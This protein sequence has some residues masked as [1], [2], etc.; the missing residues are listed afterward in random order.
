M[1]APPTLQPLTLTPCRPR[2]SQN[3]CAVASSAFSV[4]TADSGMTRPPKLWPRSASSRWSMPGLPDPL[5]GRP[6]ARG[7]VA[8]REAAQDSFHRVSSECSAV[9]L[10]VDR[11]LGRPRPAIG[12]RATGT[13]T[14][15]STTRR[16]TPALEHVEQDLRRRPR[17]ASPAPGAGRSRLGPALDVPADQVLE[18]GD[19]ADERGGDLVLGAALRQGGG[20]QARRPSSGPALRRGR[21]AGSGSWSSG[22][23]RACGDHGQDLLAPAAAGAGRLK[24]RRASRSRRLAGWRLAI[25]TSRSSRRTWRS[26]RF[27][28]AG[29]LARHSASRRAISRPRRLSWC[30]PGSRRQRSSSARF[31]IAVDEIARTRP[32]PRRSGPARASRTD[33]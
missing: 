30:R 12:S 2:W 10:T 1:S 22:T 16:A 9:W 27:V 28:P 33:E 17:P 3:A 32:R 19:V 6:D 14:A 20:E 26:G 11:R 8:V 29:L 4:I 21:S 13:S 7:T 15:G 23:A 18:V 25:A 5:D 31:W 24:S